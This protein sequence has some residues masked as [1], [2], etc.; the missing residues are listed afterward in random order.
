MVVVMYCRDNKTVY[1]IHNPSFY[2]TGVE[3]TKW[4]EI[5]KK[6]IEEWFGIKVD[7]I[8]RLNTGTEWDW[9]KAEEI[10]NDENCEELKI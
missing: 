9:E 4:I 7:E 6:S 10:L 1:V 2:E 3:T 8:I 5:N